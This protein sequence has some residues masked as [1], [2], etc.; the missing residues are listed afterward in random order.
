MSKWPP[1][2]SL[3]RPVPDAQSG[4]ASPL[5]RAKGLG[6]ARSGS[7]HWRLQRT[8]AVALI[9][10]SVWFLAALI[11][12]VSADRATASAWL[13]RPWV[14]L[15]MILFLVVLFQ[16]TRLGLQVILEDYIHS[17]RLKFA[18]VTTVQAGCYLLMA[19][20]IFSILLVA[21]R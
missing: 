7:G 12:Q 11:A 3:N 1:R 8:T 14:A 16:H 13:G 2:N 20:G 4:Y 10:L 18:L 5:R 19:I 21:L 17:D 9:P 6:S 15:P